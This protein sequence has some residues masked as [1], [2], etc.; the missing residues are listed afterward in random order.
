MVFLIRLKYTTSCTGVLYF[1]SFITCLNV[2]CYG[3]VVV[4][5]GC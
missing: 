1:K 3:R 4:S 2:V 5:F